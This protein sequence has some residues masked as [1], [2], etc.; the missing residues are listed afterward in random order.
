[1][2]LLLLVPI[3]KLAHK[4]KELLLFMG[5]GIAESVYGRVIGWM[6]GVQ[7]PAGARNF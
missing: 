7:F 4:N 1:L 5:A 6:A 3:A 2:Y